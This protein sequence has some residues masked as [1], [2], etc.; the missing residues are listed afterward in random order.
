MIPSSP[1]ESRAPGSSG[2]LLAE[3]LWTGFAGEDGGEPS[4]SGGLRV[5]FWRS[6]EELLGLPAH[7]G[8]QQPGV[9][10]LSPT[11]YIDPSGGH[12]GRHHGDLKPSGDVRICDEG[13]RAW[14]A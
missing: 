14:S 7:W 10:A 6:V 12:P 2:H 11:S 1:V 5:V 3:L 13:Q 4:F 8:P 9:P